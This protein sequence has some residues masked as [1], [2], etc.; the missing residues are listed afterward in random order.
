M[1]VCKLMKIAK[2]NKDHISCTNKQGNVLGYPR[3]KILSMFKPKRQ[4][5]NEIF[6]TKQNP[7]FDKFNYETLCSGYKGREGASKET[8][9]NVLAA[10]IC[11]CS[12][13]W[14]K[15]QKYIFFSCVHATL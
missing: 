12:R 8:I 9:R 2:E 6:A 13:F 5:A 15:N 14:C 4:Y 7:T 11:R 1:R 10:V 3:H